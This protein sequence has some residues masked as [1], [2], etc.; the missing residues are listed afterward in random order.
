M[1]G[2]GSRISIS[3]ALDSISL[4]R[5]PV[6]HCAPALIDDSIFNEVRYRKSEQ[7]EYTLLQLGKTI[8]NKPSLVFKFFCVFPAAKQAV[9]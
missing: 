8:N 2:R 6:R 9:V 4:A 5:S 7:E 3:L 1:Q